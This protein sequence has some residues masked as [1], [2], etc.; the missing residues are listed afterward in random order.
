LRDAEKAPGAAI[1]KGP[2]TVKNGRPEQTWITAE[3]G[4]SVMTF[5]QYC[6]DFPSIYG[7]FSLVKQRVRGIEPPCAAWEAAVL[8]L[9]YTRVWKK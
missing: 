6:Y 4:G 7:H 2:A 5:R 8:P 3:I 9:N 1:K